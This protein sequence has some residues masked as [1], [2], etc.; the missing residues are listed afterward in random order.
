MQLLHALAHANTISTTTLPH[1]FIA[2]PEPARRLRSRLHPVELRNHRAEQPMRQSYLFRSAPIGP[3]TTKWPTL[4]RRT[5]PRIPY[6]PHLFQLT[7]DMSGRC[8]IVM[9]IRVDELEAESQSLQDV[10]VRAL[11]VRVP[12]RILE[13]IEHN[14]ARQRRLGDRARIDCPQGIRQLHLHETLVIRLGHGSTPH[15]TSTLPQS[16]MA[17]PEPARRPVKG[18]QSSPRRGRRSCRSSMTR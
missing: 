6:L 18:E 12:P 17:V 3:R 5:P 11:L 13:V 16:V 7:K 2:V 14:L 1:S 10:G 15:Y 8:R 9:G 4:H